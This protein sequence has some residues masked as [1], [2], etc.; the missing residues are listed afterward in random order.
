MFKIKL[1]NASY[2]HGFSLSPI[3]L[4]IPGRCI[5]G[6]LGP[7]G[8]G[9]TTLLKAICQDIPSKA[10]FEIDGRDLSKMNLKER[11]RNLAIVPQNVEKTPVSVTDFVLSGRTPFKKWYQLSFSKT[12]E[13]AARSNLRKVGLLEKYSFEELGKKRMDELSG[14]ERQLC[15][16]ARALCQQPKVL[17][18]DEPTANLDMA[19]QVRILRTI[20]G[21]S[22]ENEASIILV[23]H[24][25]NL[26]IAYC[27]RIALISK[28]KI[29]TE[30]ETLKTLTKENLEYIYQT[31]LCKGKHP[32][33]GKT[34]YLPVY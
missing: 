31:E 24:D 17:L 14:G 20:Q 16:L 13:E 2:P 5:T 25:I 15:A 12:D 18:L 4:E 3:H 11:A 8:S 9:K 1:Q 30:G 23:V 33:N 26:A 34:I 10:C 21:I 19:N 29:I 6:I 28:G 22:L 7:N 32:V 27:Q